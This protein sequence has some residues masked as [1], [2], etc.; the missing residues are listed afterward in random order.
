MKTRKFLIGNSRERRAEAPS[1]DYVQ[2]AIVSSALDHAAGARAAAC[3]KLE[4]LL[5][6]F[7]VPQIL[8]LTFAKPASSMAWRASNRTLEVRTLGMPFIST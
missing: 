1:L 8:G 6:W 3:R 4:P 7:W 2:R 5:Q